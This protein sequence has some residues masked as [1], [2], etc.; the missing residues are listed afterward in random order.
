[1]AGRL[2]GARCRAPEAAM[3]RMICST[4]TRRKMGI[5]LGLPIGTDEVASDD[6]KDDDG[7]DELDGDD[8]GA[9]FALAGIIPGWKRIIPA[10]RTLVDMRSLGNG[11]TRVI[12]AVIP[13]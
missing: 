13:V 8:D 4:R 2:V 3:F 1:M 10:G 6:D 7:I 9:E 12:V 11:A 5:S